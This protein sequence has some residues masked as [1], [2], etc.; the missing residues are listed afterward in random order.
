M[1]LR[2]YTEFP[3]GLRL[4]EPIV[5]YFELDEGWLDIPHSIPL[6]QTDHLNEAGWELKRGITVFEVIRLELSN[7][8]HGAVHCS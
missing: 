5:D 1:S 4:D 8:E 3:D 7:T 6:S 2:V